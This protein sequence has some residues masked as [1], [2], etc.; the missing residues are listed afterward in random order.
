[1]SGNV[2]FTTSAQGRIRPSAGVRVLVFMLPVMFI[3]LGLLLAIA[4]YGYVSGARSA[5]GT[6]VGHQQFDLGVIPQV[7]FLVDGA[8]VTAPL[9]SG[10]NP[11][12]VPVGATIQ[13]IYDPVAP[14]HIRL[15]GLGY[16]Y[17]FPGAVMLI[18][19]GL[20]VFSYLLWRWLIAIAA[21][22]PVGEL[23]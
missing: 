16:N 10:I 7:E 6:V 11:A 9:G 19:L 20:F 15:P 13:I 18:G 21:R 22:R 1:M 2:F 3:A 12:L 8:P 17:G 5:L 14:T 4:S 23:S